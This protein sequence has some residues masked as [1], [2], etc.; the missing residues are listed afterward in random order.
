VS[1]GSYTE[2]NA[3]AYIS[4]P[5]GGYVDSIES[6]PTD[7]DYISNDERENST[8][9]IEYINNSNDSTLNLD[10]TPSY[11]IKELGSQQIFAKRP[12]PE[13]RV[14]SSDYGSEKKQE[15][16]LVYDH[17]PAMKIETADLLQSARSSTDF[18]S[19]NSGD[20]ST[21]NLN[22]SNSS[23]IGSVSKPEVECNGLPELQVTSQLS[24]N[25]GFVFPSKRNRSQRKPITRDILVNTHR[26]ILSTFNHLVQIYVA[27]I[28]WIKFNLLAIKLSIKN[29]SPTG[30][31]MSF[32][33]YKF[34]VHLINAL[35]FFTLQD[36]RFPTLRLHEEPPFIVKMIFLY[37]FHFPVSHMS[38]MEQ[39]GGT[40]P[41]NT[42]S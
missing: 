39:I 34:S 21:N 5:N 18:K 4:L 28:S 30:R 31:Q 19:A 14:D 26:K 16:K 17:G 23:E 9:S 7:F 6:I 12:K 38:F 25:A 36:L 11:G 22:F 40:F 42:T 15:S 8:V 32:I 35:K 3:S 10:S 20:L 37:D 13:Y 27:I 41:K 24:L 29:I 2:E 33:P 1:T